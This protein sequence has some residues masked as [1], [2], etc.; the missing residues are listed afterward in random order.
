MLVH[1]RWLILVAVSLTGGFIGTWSEDIL[2]GPA[3]SRST[4]STS[5]QTDNYRIR[6]RILSDL[7]AAMNNHYK[8]R[9]VLAAAVRAR[10]VMARQTS[11][12][13]LMTR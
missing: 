4:A 9:H 13:S 11:F 8:D 12:T 10:G 6:F 2:A 1:T 7:I 5:A 3:N